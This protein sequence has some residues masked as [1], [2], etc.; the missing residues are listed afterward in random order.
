MTQASKSSLLTSDQT[1][2]ALRHW[3][4]NGKAETPLST[5]YLFRKILQETEQSTRYATNQLLLQG[6]EA[7]KSVD[8]NA[9][10]LLQLRFLE[11]Q[12]PGVLAKSFNM[13]ESAFFAKQ[14]EA[15]AA[16][17]TTITNMDAAARIAQQDRLYQRL[18]APTYVELIGVEPQIDQLLQQLCTPT[19]PWLIA[20]EGLGGMGK[21]SLA[22]QTVQRLIAR[23]AYDEIG[24]ISA[25]HK[26]LTLGGTVTT[27]ADPIL[28]AEQLIQMLAGQLLPEIARAQRDN[29][30]VLLSALRRHLKQLPHV[31][32]IDNLETLVDL[33]ALLPTLQDLANPS[34]FLLTSREALYATPNIYHFRMPEL[35]E[36]DALALIHQE[37][38][39]SNL[40]ALAGLSDAELR[41]IFTTVGGNPLALRLVT[42]QA[43]VYTLPS[44]LQHLAMASGQT[45]ESLYNYIYWHAWQSLDPTSRSVLLIMPLVNPAGDD[46]E[47]IAEIGE[48]G[49]DL[50]R[51]ALNQLVTLNLV[52]TRGSSTERCYRIH[53]LTRT[54]LL[55]QVLRWQ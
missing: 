42:A 29:P 15:M 22:H 9:A 19:A 36:Q 52:D 6:L 5:L 31:V 1:R 38:E 14:H 13:S 21:T 55:E 44:I 10:T 4:S 11:K 37:I 28:T 54:F 12:S 17:T 3:H 20:L 26:R 16:L 35:S 32:V 41:P 48:L 50:V 53:G 24:W 25:R 2:A 40:T 34:K 49:V 51:G 27:I 43:H 45:A 18:E 39:V 46:I 23:G 8:E 30:A 7:L 33:E 47:T